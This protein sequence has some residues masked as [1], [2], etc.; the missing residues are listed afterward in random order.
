MTTQIPVT[1]LQQ[2]E[3]KV[4]KRIMKL[5]FLNSFKQRKSLSKFRLGLLH[6]RIETG[7]FVRPRLEPEDRVCLICR[8]GEVENE[9]HFL[10]FCNEYKHFRQVLFGHIS[11]YDEF[12]SW[13]SN[14]KLRYLVNDASMVKQTAIYIVNAFD[15]RST[16]L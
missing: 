6:L 11:D 13:D 14:S 15:H 16:L 4:L 7:R 2:S 3:L 5:G 10:L 8:S 9:L 1:L 12:C